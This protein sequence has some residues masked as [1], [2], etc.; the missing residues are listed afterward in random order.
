V[1]LRRREFAML[2]SV[3]LTPRGFNRMLNYESIFYGLKALL[4][5]L[6]VGILISVWMYN[7]F[8]NMFEFAFALPEKR[9]SSAWPGSSGSSL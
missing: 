5:G 7:A 4:Y 2:K 9:S 3:G 6:P 1:A 8:G